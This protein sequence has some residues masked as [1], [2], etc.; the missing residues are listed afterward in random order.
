VHHVRPV[1]EQSLPACPPRAADPSPRTVTVLRAGASGALTGH[2]VF[3]RASS[4]S[5]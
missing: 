2:L 3:T 1:G 5:G 4:G